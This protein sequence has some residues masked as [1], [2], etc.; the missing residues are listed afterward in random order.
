MLRLFEFP[1]NIILNHMKTVLKLVVLASIL[2]PSTLLARVDPIHQVI[3]QERE[4]QGQKKAGDGNVVKT[5]IKNEVKTDVKEKVGGD[6]VYDK[7]KSNAPI[8]PE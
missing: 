3:K 7:A 6:V 8:Q 5:G 1:K 2:F 4:V